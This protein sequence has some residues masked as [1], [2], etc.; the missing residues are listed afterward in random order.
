[1]TKVSIVAYLVGGAFQNL[2]YLGCAVLPVRCDCSYAMD[3]ERH[4]SR[5]L[6]VYATVTTKAGPTPACVHSASR[7]KSDLRRASALMFRGT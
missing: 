3:I 4:T 6:N 2:A 1:M 5:R 7:V